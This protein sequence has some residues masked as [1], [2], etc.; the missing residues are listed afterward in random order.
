[1]TDGISNPN[2]LV[3]G[4]ASGIGLAAA[5]A[6]SSAG[7]NVLLFD[8]NEDALDQA[9]GSLGG[10]DNILTMA[11]SV[12]NEADVEAAVSK[13]A[14]VHGRVDSVVTSAGI[15]K[16][17][18]ALT[19]DL[20]TFQKTM[21]INVIGSWIAAQQAARVMVDNGGGSII[22]I[23]SVYG[24]GGA[25]DRT[26]Y[27]A[28]KGAI[29]NLTKSLAVEWGPL[30]IRVNAVAPTGVRTPMVQELIDAGTYNMVGVKA[31]TPLGRLAEAEE[32]AD[33]CVFLA[34]NQATMINGV[35][36][37]VDGGWTANG[38]TMAS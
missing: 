4:G 18:P 5:K 24:A 11:G 1:M 27:C 35:I 30:G 34:S 9:K 31:R 25:P 38:Y 3:T 15:V 19:A 37:P 10:G 7:G 23:G 36:L 26:A 33:A 29:H 22:F 28:S 6:F 17:E 32:I 12:I 16:V 14:S 8:L 21:D 2:V 13:L 20:D